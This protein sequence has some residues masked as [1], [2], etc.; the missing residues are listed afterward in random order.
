[1]LTRD[2]RSERHIHY[3]NR[4]RNRSFENTLEI[5]QTETKE[6]K[7]IDRRIKNLEV[8]L[9]DARHEL[10]ELNKAF[11][12]I[13][14]EQTVRKAKAQVGID[15]A[16][17]ALLGEVYQRCQ[18][19]T[20]LMGG[21]YS[22]RHELPNAYADIRNWVV[23]GVFANGRYRAPDGDYD[24]HPLHVEYRLLCAATRIMYHDNTKK[25]EPLCERI[26]T[27][28]NK[29]WVRYTDAEHPVTKEKAA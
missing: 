9:Q 26:N 15:N 7:Q 13:S 16:T 8:E 1:M 29:A 14:R 24:Y 22:Y 25:G 5:D 10:Y 28:R 27:A 11:D 19:A 23:N 20:K 3:I 12:T 2:E 21:D 6:Y 18:Q 4:F 17:D